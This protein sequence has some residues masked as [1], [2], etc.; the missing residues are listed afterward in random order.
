VLQLE[1]TV[2]CV[3][4]QIG[5]KAIRNSCWPGLRTK[6]ITFITSL[7]GYFPT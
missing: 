4:S 5:N 3:A 1:I 7:V 6:F 2:Y